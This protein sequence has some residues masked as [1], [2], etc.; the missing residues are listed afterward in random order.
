MT[1]F[2]VAAIQMD[3]TS[4]QDQNLSVVADF[5]GEAAKKGA[6]LI[7][8]PETMAYLGRDYAA[9]SE[10]VPGGKT[11]TYLSTLARKYGVD[12]EGGSLYERNENDPARPYNTTFLLGP[13]GAFLGKYS[14]LHPFDV[15][16]DSGVTSRESSHVAPGHEIVTVKT[17]GVGTLGFGICYD[18]RFG[19][20]FRLMALR[21]AQILVLPANFTE[22]TGRAHWEVLVRARAIENECYV[23]AP[24]Q[25]GKKPRFT[26]YGHS[27]IV[28]PRGKV[29][30]E[31]DGT[32]TGVIYAPIDLDLV[33]KVR[34]E[35]FTLQN[36]REDIYSL[37]LK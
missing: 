8:L 26:A 36:R 22:A 29:L 37:C 34:K 31:A 33:S 4:N 14:K 27:L 11:A 10:A 17:A 20:L 9:L 1:T 19:E 25:V 2:L 32:E 21:G 18:L 28:D 24:N 12:I 13:D 6:K 35:T 5:I 23:I 7:A 16:L 3:T 30:A 15:V